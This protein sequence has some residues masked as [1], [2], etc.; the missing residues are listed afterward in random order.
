MGLWDQGGFFEIVYL[1]AGV[2]D[3][4]GG[5]HSGWCDGVVAGGGVWG[6][7]GGKGWG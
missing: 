1:V 6:G 7:R 3:R 5:A 4:V 2:T